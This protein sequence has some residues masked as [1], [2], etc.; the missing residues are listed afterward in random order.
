M[1]K[2]I[3]SG[4]EYPYLYGLQAMAIYERLT[5]EVFGVGPATR[6]TVAAHYSCLLAADIDFP[7]SF[8]AFARAVDNKQ[9]LDALNEAL[10]LEVERWNG[11]TPTSDEATKNKKKGKR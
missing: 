11:M 8:E 7:L 1:T 10:K 9:S 4:I 3:V 5:G 2:V 6:A